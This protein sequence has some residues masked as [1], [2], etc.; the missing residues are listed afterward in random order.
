MQ[1]FEYAML[2][3]RDDPSGSGKV[4]WTVVPTQS[5]VIVNSL[6]VL[7]LLRPLGQKGWEVVAATDIGGGARPEIILKRTP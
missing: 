1:Q 4:M 5:G 2:T 7:D 3:G 6:N